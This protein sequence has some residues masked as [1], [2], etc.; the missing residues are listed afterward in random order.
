MLLNVDAEA[1]AVIL[2]QFLSA[3]DSGSPQTIRDGV[4][5][6]KLGFQWMMSQNAPTHANAT[7]GTVVTNGTP[8]TVNFAGSTT[9]VVSGATAIGIGD[10]FSIAGDTTQYTINAGSTTTN[11]L[12]YPALKVAVP[13]STAITVYDS[14]A[15]G[16]DI[17]M[18]FHPYAF[19]FVTRPLLDVMTS[20]GNVIQTLTDPESGLSMR[21]ELTRQYKQ[22]MV[23]V[24]ILYGVAALKPEL[25]VVIYG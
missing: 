15:S 18:A 13:N 10:K 23:E 7:T 9:L 4:V 11:W 6:T 19:T 14:G 8:P 1:N 2:S 22:T 20:S 21:L 3:S 16:A 5:G 12:I 17:S 25:A 24:D